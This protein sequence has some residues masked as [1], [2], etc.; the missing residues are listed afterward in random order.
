VLWVAAAG[1]A[2]GLLVLALLGWQIL[3]RELDF[4]ATTLPA[5]TGTIFS[6]SSGCSTGGRRSGG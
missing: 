6:D 3:G 2:L 1:R 4:N 5:T